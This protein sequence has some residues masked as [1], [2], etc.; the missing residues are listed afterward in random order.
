MLFNLPER[1]SI[2]N[3]EHINGYKMQGLAICHIGVRNAVFVDRRLRRLGCLNVDCARVSPR[4]RCFAFLNYLSCY[5]PW[6]LSLA[7]VGRSHRISLES[8]SQIF[9][10]LAHCVLA[11]T[12]SPILV[13]GDL[14]CPEG[15]RVCGHQV[16]KSGK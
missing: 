13:G 15:T 6:S 1:P 12:A 2:L 16:L 14:P 7:G 4:L 8:M 3:P 9:Y 5:G 10:L 11:A